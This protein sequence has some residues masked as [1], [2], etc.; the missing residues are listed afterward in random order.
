MRT[1]DVI[2]SGNSEGICQQQKPG[3]VEHCQSSAG[4]E[5]HVSDWSQC[6]V[7]CG[8]QVRDATCSAD[9]TAE[10]LGEL[11][12]A[13]RACGAENCATNMGTMQFSL[14]IM[15]SESLTEALRELVIVYTRAAL[16]HVLEIPLALV[17][18][19][20]AT[21]D[22]ASGSLT[23]GGGQAR[24][25]LDVV[26]RL[27]IEVAEVSRGQ[28]SM[29]NV[30]T[31]HASVGRELR[32]LLA[33]SHGRI[34]EGMN[35]WVGEQRVIESPVEVSRGVDAHGESVS[36]NGTLDAV[37]IT[38]DQ[39]G[40]RDSSKEVSIVGFVLGVLVTASLGLAC[41]FIWRSWSSRGNT[42]AKQV[43]PEP[44]QSKI[45][46][47]R[48]DHSGE[49][50]G[51]T[52]DVF[53]P[54]RLDEADLKA[55]TL[56]AEHGSPR[57]CPSKIASSTIEVPPSESVQLPECSRVEWFAPPCESPAG[58][59]PSNVMGFRR[60]ANDPDSELQYNSVLRASG[61]AVAGTYTSREVQQQ[62]IRSDQVPSPCNSYDPCPR[63]F[64]GHGKAPPPV[65]SI[66]R[67]LS[68]L[69]P[70][71]LP[72]HVDDEESEDIDSDEGGC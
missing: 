69:R 44:T 59:S 19:S 33:V 3:E 65:P 20:E 72:L 50:A 45:A 60:E 51:L 39:H 58:E 24:R 41:F 29:L 16:A 66:P 10:C 32:K 52:L 47:V 12:L 68:P 70:A 15:F 61:S 30:S 40:L 34:L 2:C 56:A 71:R 4:C 46:D 28:F 42:Y 64:P 31:G 7:D 22:E 36:A 5:W 55:P 14:N 37:V 18:V 9:S 38:G 21:A 67:P 13:A 26:L 11:P 62:E 54:D 57:E 25:R 23:G 49:V 8:P 27:L 35:L 17:R 53:R 48:K 63:S 6:G 43:A 1:R